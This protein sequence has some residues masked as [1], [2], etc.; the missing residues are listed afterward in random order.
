MAEFDA[1]LPRIGK[2]GI[3]A[4]VAGKISREFD[5]SPHIARDDEGRIWMI[6]G[7]R[8]CISLGLPARMDHDMIEAGH[9]CVDGPSLL[10]GG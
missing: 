6:G 2:L 5:S 10:C 1:E 9:R 7:Q 3:V 4:S 8:S